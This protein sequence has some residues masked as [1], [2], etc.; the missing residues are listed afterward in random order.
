[1]PVDN[2]RYALNAA[3]ARWGSLYDA[4][5]GTDVFPKSRRTAGAPTIP[6]GARVVAYA[7][8]FLDT[9]VEAR[10]GEL[11]R[12]HRIRPARSP[13]TKAIRSPRS[14]AAYRWGSPTRLPSSA[15][16]R[17]ADGSAVSC[18]G[19]TGC[20]S[21]S[22]STAITHRQGHPAGLK[23]VVL[24]AAVTT[25]M[26]CEDSVAAVDADDKARVY[27]NWFGIM[28]GTLE[29]SFDKGGRTVSRRLNPDKSFIAPDGTTLT[30]PGRSLLLIRN[31]GIHMETDAVT[32]LDDRPIPEGF[33]DAMVTTLAAPS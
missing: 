2:S 27:R 4:L 10:A 19:I 28:A 17:R 33:L 16:A 22:R 24:E 31:V 20:I 11:L 18:C 21:S 32:T 23:D 29:T 9:H 30:L 5:Y 14:R 15:T 8:A 7:R 26:D 3:N 1:M 13:G 6:P 12:G 25:I